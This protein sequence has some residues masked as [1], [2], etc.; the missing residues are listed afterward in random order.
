MSYKQKID[1]L[2][3]QQEYIKFNIRQIAHDIEQLPPDLGDLFVEH[4][5]EAQRYRH[6]QDRIDALQPRWRKWLGVPY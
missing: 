6:L 4:E 2:R 3:K 5:Q 1:Y